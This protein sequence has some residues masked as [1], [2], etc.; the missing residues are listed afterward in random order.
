MSNIKL[1]KRKLNLD[2]FLHQVGTESW[3]QIRNFC[4]FCL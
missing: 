3:Y 4:Y 1:E 2:D